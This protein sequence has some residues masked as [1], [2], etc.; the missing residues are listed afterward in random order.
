MK[1]IRSCLNRI[2]NVIQIQMSERKYNSLKYI[3]KKCPESNTLVVVFSGFP[4]NAKAKYNYMRTLKD[5][6]CNKLFLL[7]NFGYKKRG[8]YYLGENGKFYVQDLVRKL[9]SEIKVKLNINYAITVGSSK[10]G[11][12]A[13]YHG[14]RVGADA[15]IAGAPQYFIGNYLSTDEHQN[16]LKGITG[17]GGVELL[18][19]IVRN[20]IQNCGKQKPKI[21]LH[22]SQKE[23]TYPVHI[24][25][26]ISDMKRNNFEVICDEADYVEHSEVAKFF[27][28]FLINT[29]NNIIEKAKNDT[30]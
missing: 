22:Y 25:D 27:P 28:T 12:S 3:L 17:G 6:N 23:H 8:A 30:I 19:D 21:Y 29:I 14:L 5:F 16:I 15:I 11:T 2:M 1:N 24:S 7:D 20:E 18:N 9:I 4:G 26:L 13:I 10:G